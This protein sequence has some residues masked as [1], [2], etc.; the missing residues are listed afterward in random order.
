MKNLETLSSKKLARRYD[1]DSRVVL[2]SET[3][4]IAKSLKSILL[5]QDSLAVPVLSNQFA[6]VVNE[7][8]V[9]KHASF[10][11]TKDFFEHTVHRLVDLSS[12]RK[13]ARC[14]ELAKQIIN[15]GNITF[16]KVNAPANFD[17]AKWHDRQ[18]ALVELQYAEAEPSQ[19]TSYK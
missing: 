11:K 13:G 15:Q 12:K 5:S 8:F 14:I 2:A 9:L 4:F 7:E 17:F 1:I 19:T 6:V 16:K 3:L 18:M 10:E